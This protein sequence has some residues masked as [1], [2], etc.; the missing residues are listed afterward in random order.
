M[1]TAL[2][3]VLFSLIYLFPVLRAH[4]LL[5]FN[6]YPPTYFDPTGHC[7]SATVTGHFELLYPHLKHT[8]HHV[9][10]GWTTHPM[11]AR[12]RSTGRLPSTRKKDRF[13]AKALAR[14]VKCK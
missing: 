3:C 13:I 5:R 10:G 2:G 7:P 1:P 4:S 9:D 6:G 11:T 8:A 12:W 14:L